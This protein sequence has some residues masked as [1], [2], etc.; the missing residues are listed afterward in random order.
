M[1]RIKAADIEGGIGLGVALGLRLR[2]HVLEGAPFGLHQRQDIVA[3]AIE[4][5]R[6]ARDAVRRQRLAQGLDHRDAARD[7]RFEFQR[8]TALFG[9]YRQP[10]AVMRQQRLVGRDDRLARLQRRLDGQPRGAFLA[11]NEFDKHIDVRRIGDSDGIGQPGDTREVNAAILLGVARSHGGDDDLAAKPQ[12]QIL[13]MLL[14]QLEHTTAHGA[15]ARNANPEWTG[16]RFRHGAPHAAKS[17]IRRQA[18]VMPGFTRRRKGPARHDRLRCWQPL[19][20]TQGPTATALNKGIPL[21]S[22]IRNIKAEHRQK[23]ANVRGYKIGIWLHSE[24]AQVVEGSYETLGHVLSVG[25]GHSSLPRWV[26]HT[27]RPQESEKVSVCD[28]GQ[29]RCIADVEGKL[30]CE[31]GIQACR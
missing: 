21:P 25:L 12:R 18:T 22:R 31:I 20:S 10:S 6:H 11:A 27:E 15:Q 24:A 29:S 2:Q 3:G 4:N 28:A 9:Q 14:Q 23:L 17:A 7:G 30:I 1:R 26:P 16:L 8:H 19:W 5:A 13:A